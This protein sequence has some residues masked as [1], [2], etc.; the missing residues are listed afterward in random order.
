[1]AEETA[2]ENK[3]GMKTTEFW[4]SS[5]GPYGVVFA[6]LY[7]VM[8]QETIALIQ[9]ACQG[10]PEWAQALA[11][12]GIKAITVIGAIMVGGKSV[13]ATK[14]YTTWRSQIKYKGIVT[15]AAGPGKS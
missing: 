10:L 3:S 7:G 15:P 4:M 11:A 13:E 9:T 8:D 5:L 12:L 6:L 1:M 2:S 14:L